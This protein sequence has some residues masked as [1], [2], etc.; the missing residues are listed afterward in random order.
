MKHYEIENFTTKPNDIILM[1]FNTDDYTFN[2][3]LQIFNDL[4][5]TFSDN[6]VIAIPQ[7]ITLETKTKQEIIDYLNKEV[8]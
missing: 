4:K 3:A 8:D 6:I 2:E 5:A 7:G 1:K